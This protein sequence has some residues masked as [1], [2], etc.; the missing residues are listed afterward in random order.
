MRLLIRLGEEG[1]LGRGLQGFFF[2]VDIAE[3]FL[4]GWL[5]WS[6]LWWKGLCVILQGL[7]LVGGLLTGGDSARGF[8]GTPLVISRIFCQESSPFVRELPGG[9][10]GMGLSVSGVFGRKLRELMGGGWLEVM[11]VGWG[12]MLGGGSRVAEGVEW[13]GFGGLARLWGVCPQGV[14]LQGPK[15]VRLKGVGPEGLKVH[16]RVFRAF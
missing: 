1:R 5:S 9:L 11:G 14:R 6:W 13:A 16:L 3:S 8:P 4:G 10:V 7:F 2:S 12:S 15:D